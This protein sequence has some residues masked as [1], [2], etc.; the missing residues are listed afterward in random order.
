M[1]FICIFVFAYLSYLYFPSS[2]FMRLTFSS[3]SSSISY[4][5]NIGP[6]PFPGRRSYEAIKSGF[7]FFIKLLLAVFLVKDAC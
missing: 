2:F 3:I 4:L 7:S 5:Q 1:W 6:A